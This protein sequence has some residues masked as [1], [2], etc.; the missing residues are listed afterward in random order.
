MATLGRWR[1][2]ANTDTSTFYL[3]DI[4]TGHVFSLNYQFQDDM[5]RE[6]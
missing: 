3:I 5:I 2:G 6:L 4:M 1:A